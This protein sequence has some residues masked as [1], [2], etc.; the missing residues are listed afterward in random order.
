MH[1]MRAGVIITA[2]GRSARFGSSDK[3]GQD[4]GGRPVIVRTV[5]LFS[6]R[7]EVAS[8]VVAGPPEE[9][10]E[11]GDDRFAVFRDRYGATLSF[12]GVILVP[13][14]TTDRWETVQRALEAV[15][16]DSSHIAVH[17]GA[18]PATSR[19]VLDRVFEAASTLPAVVPAVD[20]SGTIKR[21]SGE[22]V[23]VEEA[24]ED[25]LADLILGDAGKQTI[26]AREVAET[27][28]RSGLVEVQTP[29]VF[30]SALLRRA[31][32]Q[33]DL[34]GATDDAMVVERLG[35]TVHVVDGGATNI[36]IT[37]PEDMQL[38]RAI[39]GVRPPEERPAHKRF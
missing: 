10:D 8:I 6:K 27:V 11:N 38:V 14:G 24:D 21:V 33:A 18:R 35:E 9:P 19:D 5:E 23:T 2:A 4:L 16:A 15:P 37:A 25:A 20:L 30:E 36:K 17:D 32:E 22:S 12:H 34:T 13:G 7:D 3:L 26:D 29:Q 28:D 39:L 31:Y 1:G